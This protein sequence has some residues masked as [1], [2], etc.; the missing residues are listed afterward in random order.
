MRRSI[1]CTYVLQ[2]LKESLRMFPTAPAI[3]MAAKEDTTIG[4]QY[5]IKK[6]NMVIMHALALHRDKTVWGEDADRFN[7]DHFS[8]EAERERPVNAFKPFGNGQ[9]A[10][11]GRQFALQEAVLT[12]GMILQR[13]KLVDHT[14]YKLK[15]KEALTIKPE[16]FK[17]KALLRDPATRAAR[18][19]A[20][21][22]RCRPRSS[23]LPPRSRRPRATGLRCWCC[24]APTSAPPRTWRA[25][26]P[27]PARC[28]ASRPRSPRSTTMRSAC[29]PTAPSRSSA[30]RTTAW[31]PTTRPSSIAGSTRPTTA[32]NGVRFSVFGC[33]NTDW[34]STYQAV[35][36]RIDERLAALGATR[37]HA[38]GEGDARE[39]MDGAFQDWSD[40]LW[41][42]SSPPSTSS[43]APDT[44]AQSEPL[45]TLEELPPPQKNALVDAL[46]AV[47][48]RVIDNRELQSAGSERCRRPL[49]A[50]RRAAAARGRE[51]PRRR[52][53]ERGAAQR[54]GAGGARDGALRLR[55]QGAC[56]A[57]G[58]SRAA[59]PRCRSTK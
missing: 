59:R 19:S 32:L 6:R 36:R 55:P 4:G 51:L 1:D 50:A 54:S 56:A 41:P 24:R 29:R 52:P 21:R 17:I 34:A 13:F 11:I 57:V 25:N 53:P 39:D 46:G 22:S 15:I 35:P 2:V 28:A 30:R 5:T 31:R 47:G 58:G 49:D 14:G 44:P 10:C 16:G 20:S 38:R 33:G 26:W 9:R 27:R 18:R 48:M 43:R 42:G 7:P 3:A 40:A 23:G 12:L 8:R 45:Y 37:V